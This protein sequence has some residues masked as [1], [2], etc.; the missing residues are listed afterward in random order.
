[1]KIKYWSKFKEY[2]KVKE[3]G[4]LVVSLFFFKGAHLFANVIPGLRVVSM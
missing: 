1:M 3:N 2:F 4:Q